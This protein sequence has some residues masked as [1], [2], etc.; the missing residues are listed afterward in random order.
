MKTEKILQVALDFVDLKRAVK[1]AR[2]AVEGGADWLEVG[3]P[4]IKSEGLN[5]VRTLKKLFPKKTIVADLKTF[6][7]GR[8][9]VEMAAK[10]GADI[11][12]VMAAAPIETIVD[13]VLAGR[14]YGCRIMVDFLGIADVETRARQ[15]AETGVDF[16]NIHLGIDQQMQG[17]V[18]FE[19]IKKL[20]GATSVP[21]VASGGINSETAPLA[22]KAGATIVIV[23]GAIIKSPDAATATRLI[24]KAMAEQ[25]SIPTTLYRRAGT[26][27][28]IFK[29]LKN[30]STANISDAM[31]RAFG[32]SGII[33]VTQWPGM[34][35]VGEAFTVRTCPGDWAK[36][37]EAIDRAQTGQV[38]VINAGG[39]PPAVWG[40]LATNSSVVRK[41]AGV[42]IDGAIR[43]VSE[44]RK[45][46]FPAYSRQICPQ[47][48]E[49]KG[50][51]EIGVPV[52]VGG[53][54]VF[55]GDWVIGDEDGVVIVP[56][57]EA[58]EFA[59]R[60]M[61]VLEKENRLR[62]EIRKGGTLAQ[63]TELLR[64]EKV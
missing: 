57:E 20:T 36:P 41:L 19:I 3:T 62:A 13:S 59:N 21:V 32:L 17:K 39:V 14:N 8:A 24:K 54:R 25:K 34:K 2:E 35:M 63:I 16:F 26:T 52:Y 61:D 5:A 18:S 10:S 50:F 40:D 38:I 29:I 12:S 47:A 33:P 58:I 56:K 9:E 48:G 53:C 23:G 37:V 31:H 44:I 42:V 49:P 27:A 15:L 55:P 7:A 4:L 30:V 11:V 43:D 28:E 45:L 51:G 1:V 64:W 6:D 46:K 22:L 60:A